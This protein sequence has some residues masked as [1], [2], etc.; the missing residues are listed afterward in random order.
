VEHLDLVANIATSQ[1]SINIMEGDLF[2][3][4]LSLNPVPMKSTGRAKIGPQHLA[5]MNNYGQAT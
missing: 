2:G 5:L 3:T 1:L 4:F